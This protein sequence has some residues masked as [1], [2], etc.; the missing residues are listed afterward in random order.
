MRFELLATPSR[1]GVPDQGDN[2]AQINSFGEHIGSSPLRLASPH[3]YG[4]GDV[5]DGRFV[6]VMSMALG[7]VGLRDSR[8]AHELDLRD[9][10]VPASSRAWARR[11][12]A[13]GSISPFGAPNLTR[14]VPAQRRIYFVT[15]GGGAPYRVRWFDL[16]TNQHVTGTGQGFAFAEGGVDTGALVHVPER[17]LLLCLYR[18]ASGA[19]VVEWM[20]VTAAQPTVG[21]RAVLATPL[22]VPDTWGAASWCGDSGRLL[23][24]GVA[25]SRVYELTIPT[26]LSATWPVDSHAV[27]GLT[28]PATSVW[29]KSMDYNPR[30]RTVTVLPAGLA[31]SGP[32]TVMVYRP[33]GT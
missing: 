14:Y 7:Y 21:G 29:G 13:P 19:L 33:R 28:P 9:P 10:T 1:W 15:R 3:S 22:S 25:A 8:A 20:D 30:T 2:Q 23:I 17:G 27:S 6:Q 26:L 18:A 4:G 16:E 12:A 31:Y 11:S 5:V 32:D 24:F